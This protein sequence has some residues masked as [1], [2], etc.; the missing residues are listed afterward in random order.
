MIIILTFLFVF[1][2]I[3][4]CL[5]SFLGSCV[6]L[7]SESQ[8]D[9]NFSVEMKSRNVL[10]CGWRAS[11][12][13]WS[14]TLKILFIERLPVMIEDNQTS[15][16]W[17]I[18][19]VWVS[20]WF[21]QLSKKFSIS[22]W[23]M[24]LSHWF[25]VECGH[26]LV[27]GLPK[28]VWPKRVARHSLISFQRNWFAFSGWRR[29]EVNKSDLQVPSQ[30]WAEGLFKWWVDWWRPFGQMG[31]DLWGRPLANGAWLW[32]WSRRGHLRASD[33]T[34]RNYCVWAEQGGGF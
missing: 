19:L 33:L 24:V 10:S 7:C 16:S 18:K 15:L 31:E 2:W 20:A 5:L 8:P 1:H 23:K 32:L 30:C 21:C 11:L 27:H 34:G 9:L 6:S 26:N 13:L 22:L 17:T 14:F 29:S 28:C 4:W 25:G 3:C 12:V